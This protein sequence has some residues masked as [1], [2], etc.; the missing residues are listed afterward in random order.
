MSNDT[1]RA[2]FYTLLFNCLSSLKSSEMKSKN[3][4]NRN[5]LSEDKSNI[6]LFII[7]FIDYLYEY[8]QDNNHYINLKKQLIETLGIEMRTI[9]KEN[10]SSIL[11]EHQHI[12]DMKQLLIEK[13]N[14]IEQLELMIYELQAILRSKDENMLV[15]KDIES[16][17][18]AI[19]NNK[20]KEQSSSTTLKNKITNFFTSNIK[21]PDTSLAN[22]DLETY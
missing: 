5:Q 20:S 7:E 19:D 1:K 6:H 18:I 4:I 21:I 16:N 15:I 12:N 3:E 14:H 9:V 17:L 2:T 10:I 8:I 13:Q 22:D 11:S